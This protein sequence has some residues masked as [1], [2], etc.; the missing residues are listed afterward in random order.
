MT[1][2]R[3]K[4]AKRPVIIAAA[5]L[6]KVGGVKGEPLKRDRGVVAGQNARAVVFRVAAVAVKAEPEMRR[7]REDAPGCRPVRLGRVR[8]GG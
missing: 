1:R 4:S 6:R 7:V 8:R 5:R 2:S 3:H